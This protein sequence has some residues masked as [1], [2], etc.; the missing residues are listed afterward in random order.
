MKFQDVFLK[1]ILKKYHF[2]LQ[3]HYNSVMKVF[4]W[5]NEFEIFLF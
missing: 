2:F 1:T 5:N 4:L 3:F